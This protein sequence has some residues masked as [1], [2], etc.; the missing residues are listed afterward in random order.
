MAYGLVAYWDGYCAGG[1]MGSGLLITY[2][3]K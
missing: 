1:I 3:G 2:Q